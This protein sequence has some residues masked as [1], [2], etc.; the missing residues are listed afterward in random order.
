[1]SYHSFLGILERA[2]IYQFC[3]CT[4]PLRWCPKAP[5]GLAHVTWG[6]EQHLPPKPLR[7]RVTSEHDGCAHQQLVRHALSAAVKFQP[8]S[9]IMQTLTDFK[10][11]PEKFRSSWWLRG[12]NYHNRFL[13]AL[14][15]VFSWTQH[16]AHQLNQPRPSLASG[17]LRIFDPVL[18]KVLHPLG[19]EY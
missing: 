8:S 2:Q 19:N 16:G 9:R 13:T 6:A 12:W 1:M 5:V 17:M 4:F 3:Y 18:V 11:A 15:D 14:H 7:L 10:H